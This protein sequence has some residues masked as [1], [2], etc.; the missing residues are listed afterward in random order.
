MS[1]AH[2]SAAAVVAAVLALSACVAES[3]EPGSASVSSAPAVAGP[4]VVSEEL[5]DVDTDELWLPRSVEER[6][7]VAPGWDGTPLQAEGVFLG[8]TEVGGT[9]TYTAVDLHGTALWR[10]ERPGGGSPA[11]LIG[12]SDGRPLAVLPHEDGSGGAT[13]HAYDLE[14]GEPAWGPVPSSGPLPG[15]GLVIAGEGQDAS[16][17]AVDPDTGAVLPAPSDARLVAQHGSILLTVQDGA[18]LASDVRSGTERW[19]TPLADH[20]LDPATIGPGPGPQEHALAL[21]DTDGEGQLVVDPADG[22]VLSTSAWTA[23]VDEATGVRVV[24]EEATLR[25]I[26]PAGAELWSQSVTPDL[27]LL[28]VGG[29]FA[30]LREAETVRAVNAVTGDVVEA[31]DPAGQGRIVVPSL[32]GPLGTASLLDRDQHLLATAP[33]DPPAS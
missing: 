30:Y 2:R 10:A 16:P 6:R 8:W 12:T 18:L 19:R 17:A 24:H 33:E 11:W 1:T 5:P 23:T 27:V 25:G 3:E 26:D 9:R 21:L 31:Y 20:G 4:E 7:L 29:V 13:V 32:F 14:T 22:T 28:G 15:G